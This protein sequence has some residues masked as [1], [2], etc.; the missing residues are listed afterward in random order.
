MYV[1]IREFNTSN[2]LESAFA[3]KNPEG[4]KKKKPRE[5]SQNLSWKLSLGL[6]GTDQ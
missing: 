5:M 2:S 1:N 3:V 6:K 4:K